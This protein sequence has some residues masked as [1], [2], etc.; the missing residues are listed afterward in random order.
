MLLKWLHLLEFCGLRLVCAIF[1]SLPEKS[2]SDFGGWVGRVFGPFF[3]VS[4]RARKN[5]EF[6]FPYIKE[7]VKEN[8]VRDVWDN[9]G[10]VVAEYCNLE[11][12]SK[13]HDRMEIVG[14][15]VV[16][17]L[18]DD[19]L[20]A[21]LFSAHLSNFQIATLAA[22]SLGLSIVQVYRKTNNKYI[23]GVMRYMQAKAAS[24]VI[25]KDQTKQII[26]SLM[27]GKHLFML[28][29]QRVLEGVRI[30]FIGRD[31][32]TTTSVARLCRRLRCPLVPVR[33]ERVHTHNFRVT[34]HDP[35]SIEGNTDDEVMR[36]VNSI[37]GLWVKKAPSQ[38]MWIHKRWEIPTES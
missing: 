26:K 32:L 27:D 10:R 12:I 36:E 38:W 13:N 8:I 23:D 2:A 16:E 35:I 28:V 9:L 37:I 7:T 34:F 21:I 5:L 31:A 11:K 3:P 22:R 33:V 30:P 25:S 24:G 19:G 15:H 17:K 1:G 4:N 14:A 20:P 29:D 18:R 6:V